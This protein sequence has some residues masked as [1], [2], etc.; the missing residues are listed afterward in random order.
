LLRRILPVSVSRKSGDSEKCVTLALQG[1]GAH[2]AFTWGVL[3]R[4]AEEPSLT[5]QAISGTSAGAINGALY[6]YGL[7]QNGAAG[8]KQ[9]LH[10]FWRRVSDTG[11]SIFNPYRYF[12]G[13]P[14]LLP[15][16]SVWANALSQVWSPYD[17][18]YY[19]NLLKPLLEEAI[20]FT[21]LAQPGVPALF[22]CATNVKTNQRKIFERRELTSDAVLA[23]S[24]L[25]MYFQAVT[26]NGEDYWDGGY[27]GNP[28]L[29]PLIEFASD[30][31]I[32]EVNPLRRATTPR[33]AA[34]ILDRL[35]EITF[36][37]SLVQE[38]DLIQ[39]LN[40]LID[41]G[42]LHSPKYKR[43][44]FHSI[45]AGAKMSAYGEHTKSDT[46][47]R[48]LNELHALGRETASVWVSTHLNNVGVRSSCDV[49]KEFIQPAKAGTDNAGVD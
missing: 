1:G 4:L 29:A 36:N 21:R 46:S 14:G 28:A 37:S 30:M 43:I 20:D 40:K 9:C 33:T 47:W 35:N 45:G 44:R 48:F 12:E 5:I 42:E 3:D 24:C 7:M 26:V 15:F 27:M 11:K 13:W 41:R 31:L 18:A 22:V 23:S 10:D 8:A 19:S 49:D 32:V 16:A 25:P 38:L 17:N 34:D 6:S 2:G 39:T